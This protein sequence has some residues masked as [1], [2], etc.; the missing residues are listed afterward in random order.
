MDTNLPEEYIVYSFRVG[1]EEGSNMLVRIIGIHP[2]VHIESQAR[3]LQSKLRFN[4][5]KENTFC[6]VIYREKKV[7]I[8]GV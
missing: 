3:T 4:K 2:Q 7:G 6:V 1:H 5:R 8:L